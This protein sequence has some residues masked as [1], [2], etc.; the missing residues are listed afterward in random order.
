MA[1]DP[2]DLLTPAHVHDPYPLYAE[3]RASRPVC[4]LKQGGYLI[5]RHADVTA[6]LKDPELR[7]GPSRFSVLHPSKAG[8]YE[9]SRLANNILPF[10]DPPSHTDNRRR[11]RDAYANR[12]SSVRE[13][14]PGIARRSVEQLKP[15]NV[16]DLITDV[17]QPFTTAVMTAFLELEDLEQTM[18]EETAAMFFRLFAPVPDAATFDLINQTL[19]Q[20]GG[21]FRRVIAGQAKAGQSGFSAQL[22]DDPENEEDVMFAVDAAMLLLADGIENVKYALALVCAELNGSAIET[23]DLARDKSLLERFVVEVLR[24]HSPAQLIPRIASNAVE[25]QGTRIPGET[26]VYLSLGSANRDADVFPSP[27]LVCL[28]PVGNRQRAI[29][30]GAG[31][32]ACLGGTLTVEMLTEI[33]FALLARDMV[34]LNDLSSLGFQARFGHRWPKRAEAILL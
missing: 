20:A 1:E 18:L 27:D 8:R 22:V 6:A 15:G 23:E 29:P 32:H 13:N 21:Q 17:G 34:C 19:K 26:P 12:L 10:Q 3:L 14:L 16:F 28:E 25:I 2:I 4:P 31:R 11:L 5:C 33:V 9:A 24:V 30:F 7:N